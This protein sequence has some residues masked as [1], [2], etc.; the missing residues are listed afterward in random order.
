MLWQ[1][2]VVIYFSCLIAVC[3]MTV[4]VTVAV[5]RLNLHAD[6]K[7]LVAMPAWVSDV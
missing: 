4:F 6:A 5:L 1:M 7:P 3:A 2:F